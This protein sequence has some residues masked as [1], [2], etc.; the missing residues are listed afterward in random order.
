MDVLNAL[1]PDRKPGCLSDLTLTLLRTES[2]DGPERAAAEAHLATCARCRDWQ[3]GARADFEA[4]DAEQRAALVDRMLQARAEPHQA[5]GH[6]RGRWA[7]LAGVLAAAAAVTVF[8]ATP[9]SRPGGIQT[10]GGELGLTVFR[11]RGGVVERAAS[12]EGFAAKD[13][14]R[15]EVNVP[16]PGHVLVFGVEAGGAVYRAYPNDSESSVPVD[17]GAAQLLPGAIELDAS[18]GQEVL[19]F[20]LCPRPFTVSEVAAAGALDLPQGCRSTSFELDKGR[21]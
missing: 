17:A 14:L 13:R 20:V 5:K 6:G 11:D 19:H 8:V 18:S 15:F 12:G 1:Q 2:L 4:V 7:G 9:D 16:E 21:P 3:A 10:K